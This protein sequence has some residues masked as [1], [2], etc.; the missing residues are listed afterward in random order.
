MYLNSRSNPTIWLADEELK[1]HYL[2]DKFKQYLLM[3]IV[4]LGLPY[5]QFCFTPQ[6]VPSWV[7]VIIIYNTK[8]YK[9]YNFIHV[10]ANV[11]CRSSTFIKSTITYK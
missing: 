5:W 6:G 8:N 7:E 2:S 11:F 9:I 10:L 4:H 3:A 1:W